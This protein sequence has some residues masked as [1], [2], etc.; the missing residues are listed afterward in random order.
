VIGISSDPP[1][2]VRGTTKGWRLT[3]P[4]LPD[5]EKKIIRAYGVY[6][7]NTR[8]AQPA[9]IILDRQGKVWWVYI[10][11]GY[12]KR[13]DAETVLDALRKLGPGTS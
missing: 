3:F 10:G 5:P 7:A 1:S 6:N 13:P 2:T 8:L 9:T 11:K 12:I 4:L